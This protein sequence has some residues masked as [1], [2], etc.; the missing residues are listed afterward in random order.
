MGKVL[1]NALDKGEGK[2]KNLPA[3]GC[4]SKSRTFD[5]V[6]LTPCFSWVSSSDP[7]AKTVLM[8]SSVGNR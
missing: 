4:S 7:L 2:M 3:L 5:P 1:G 8:V 6:S